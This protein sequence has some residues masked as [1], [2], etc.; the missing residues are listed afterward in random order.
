MTRN[1]GPNLQPHQLQN[2]C[3][4]TQQWLPQRRLFFVAL[5]QLPL[6]VDNLMS[7]LPFQSI[8]KKNLF[9]E[10]SNVGNKRFDLLI[11]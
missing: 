2:Q 3:S 10:R 5:G 6:L 9:L 7:N 11:A 8:S 4:L 1:A